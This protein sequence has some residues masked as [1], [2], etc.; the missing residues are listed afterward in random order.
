NKLLS[1]SVLDI[2]RYGDAVPDMPYAAFGSLELAAA[3]INQGGIVRA[4]FGTLRFGTIAGDVQVDAIHFLPGSITSVSGAGLVMPYGGS[5][6]GITYSYNGTAVRLSG[7]GSLGAA[8]FAVRHFD[9]Q[10]GSVLDLS[11]GGELTGAGFVSGRGGSVN[12]LTT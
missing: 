8:T 1:G 5:V 12:V 9:A 10:A 3:T 7:A 2:R 6:D 11:G 4:P